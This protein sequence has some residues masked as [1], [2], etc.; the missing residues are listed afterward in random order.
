MIFPESLDPL[1]LHL[2][3]Q[4]RLIAV[5]MA[6]FLNLQTT[7]ANETSDVAK[8]GEKAPDFTLTSADGKEI[9][10]SDYQNKDIVLIFSRA[11][12]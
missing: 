6:A 10:L 1:L 5:I 3:K 7:Q 2:M 9:S 12:W 11:H 8:V 4:F